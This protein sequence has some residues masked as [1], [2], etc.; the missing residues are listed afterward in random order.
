[1]QEPALR[2]VYW[3]GQ[4]PASYL[5][6]HFFVVVVGG[7]EQGIFQSSSFLKQLAGEAGL[8]VAQGHT[9]IRQR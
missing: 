7:F 4:A 3:Q 5:R 6:W 8:Q 9:K 2:Q 1:M